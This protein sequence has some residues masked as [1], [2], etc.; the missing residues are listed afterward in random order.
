MNMEDKNFER[1]NALN[2][3]MFP[4]KSS[5]LPDMPVNKHISR[6]DNKTRINDTKNNP[7]IMVIQLCTIEKYP[8]RTNVFS[9][10]NGVLHKNL[11]KEYLIL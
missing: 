6:L 11:T 4:F 10:A 5:I 3:E 1:R 7:M 8:K 9:M 2:A